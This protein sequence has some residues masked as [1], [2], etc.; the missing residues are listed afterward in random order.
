M[1][2]SLI[3]LTLI[4]Q[5]VSSIA[6]V[7][8]LDPESPNP[9]AFTILL[10][11]QELDNHDINNNVPGK[12][13]VDDPMTISLEYF[14][15]ARDIRCF[16][17]T[18]RRFNV[19]YGKYREYQQHKFY[20]LNILSRNGHETRR[21]RRPY[22][23]I[24][25][26]LHSVPCIPN[27]YVDVND[28]QSIDALSRMQYRS[29][30]EIVRG[31]TS[32]VNRPFLSLSLTNHY[33]PFDSIVMIFVFDVDHL[34]QVLFIRYYHAHFLTNRLR[35]ILEINNYCIHNLSELLRSKRLGDKGHRR[36]W[37]LGERSCWKRLWRSHCYERCPLVTIIAYILCT[38]YCL[39]LV[40]FIAVSF[41]HF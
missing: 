22:Q 13:P 27:V 11:I 40:P 26:L 12:L 41:S 3:L 39:L 10:D 18:C 37:Y 4:F 31:L 24:G 28:S 8:F 35:E 14:G 6:N 38:V 1:C 30:Q 34:A 36:T 32:R 5:S 25:H 15:E 9:L 29:K 33:C 21:W 7:D 16:R 19:I 23:S 20:A 2:Q 17:W